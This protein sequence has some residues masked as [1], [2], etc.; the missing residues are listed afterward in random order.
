MF[1]QNRPSLGGYK[2]G[3]PSPQK[4]LFSF[5]KKLSF[6]STT[7]QEHPKAQKVVKL[8]DHLRPWGNGTSTHLSHL[9]M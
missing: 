3:T 1:S 2:G 5:S 9:G 8:R 7:P 4:N 6:K